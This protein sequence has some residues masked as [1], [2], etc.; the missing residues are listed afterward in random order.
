[1]AARPR[2]RRADLRGIVRYFAAL[3]DIFVFAA[4]HWTPMRRRDLAWLAVFTDPFTRLRRPVS[5]VIG[6]K[7]VILED[8]GLPVPRCGLNRTAHAKTPILTVLSGH[9]FFTSPIQEA[10]STRGGASSY[11]FWFWRG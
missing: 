7:H 3:Q 9:F 10:Y 4:G 6:P 1:M 11:S 5:D 2:R 8:Y